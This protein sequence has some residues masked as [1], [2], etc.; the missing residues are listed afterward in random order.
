[1]LSQFYRHTTQIQ[2]STYGN[3]INY[4]ILTQVSTDLLKT[5][6]QYTGDYDLV[7]S[8]HKLVKGQGSQ[9]LTP[10]KLGKGPP[11]YKH[12]AG[13]IRPDKRGRPFGEYLS[14]GLLIRA[15]TA[16]ISS[17]HGP[18]LLSSDLCLAVNFRNSMN[19]KMPDPFL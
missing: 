7:G 2:K 9:A 3:G 16:S 19:A 17:I 13:A 15:P 6:R 5:C 11:R 8:L 12:S 1:M 10:Q 18:D 14:K 4:I